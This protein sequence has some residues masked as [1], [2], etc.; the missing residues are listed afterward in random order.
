MLKRLIGT[1]QFYWYYIISRIQ[2]KLG[3]D[4]FKKYYPKGMTEN[5]RV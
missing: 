1:I 3:I 4:I 2:L 5:D